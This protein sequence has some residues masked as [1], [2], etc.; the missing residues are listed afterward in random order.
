MHQAVLLRG[1]S[2]IKSPKFPS[3]QITLPANQITIKWLI[4]LLIAIKSNHQSNHVKDNFS[5]LIG[6]C[7]PPITNQIIQNPSETGLRSSLQVIMGYRFIFFDDLIDIFK[8]QSQSI[9]S[10]WQMIW[11]VIGLARILFN[12]IANHTL[13]DCKSISN[14]KGGM[15]GDF[16]NHPIKSFPTLLKFEI[17]QAFRKSEINLGAH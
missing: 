11:L 9:T 10:K 14:R 12:Q 3:N 4:F 13:D 15:I 2:P 17:W 16:F 6:D 8:S 5:D 7:K 1:K